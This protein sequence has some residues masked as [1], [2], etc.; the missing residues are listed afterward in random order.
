MKLKR[1]REKSPAAAEKAGRMPAFSR[2]QSLMEP[3]IVQ[4]KERE[5]KQEKDNE[6]EEPV[7]PLRQSLLAN[8]DWRSDFSSKLKNSF[9][10]YS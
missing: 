7:R 3:V 6:K 5:E 8:E 10:Y 4:I 1:K 9:G 2:K